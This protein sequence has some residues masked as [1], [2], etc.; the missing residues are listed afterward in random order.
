MRT[1]TT[2]SQNHNMRQVIY[3]SDS[4]TA[5]LIG[6]EYI[7]SERLFKSLSEEERQ[8]W[9]SHAYEV[10]SGMLT[11][12]MAWIVPEGVR[13]AAETAELS[14]VVNTYGKVVGLRKHH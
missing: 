4:P 11:T 5:R 13:K 14:Q 3:D 2:I 9:H 1:Y 6:I 8:Y 10:K 12:P 7:I